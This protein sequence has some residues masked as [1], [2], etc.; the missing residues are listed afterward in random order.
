M[1]FRK[2][3]NILFLVVQLFL[4]IEVFVTVRFPPLELLMDT[5][6]SKYLLSIKAEFS[7]RR[8]HC[9]EGTARNMPP[10]EFPSNLQNDSDVAVVQ[11]YI[12]KSDTDCFVFLKCRI[13]N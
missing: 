6:N 11:V 9:F 8:S 4:V 10:A 5:S 13:S 2:T 7:T 12:L 3:R 1:K